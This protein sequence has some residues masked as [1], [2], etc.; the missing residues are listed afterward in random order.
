MTTPTPQPPPNHPPPKSYRRDKPIPNGPED[1]A[2]R[3]ETERVR[4]ALA[5]VGVFPSSPGV[6]PTVDRKGFVRLTF[7]EAWLLLGLGKK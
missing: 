7:D 2:H 6:Y 5:D 3:A 1:I 4:K